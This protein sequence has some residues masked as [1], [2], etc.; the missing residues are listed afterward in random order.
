[1][2]PHLR[3]R[4]ISSC[5]VRLKPSLKPSPVYTMY[6]PM[7]PFTCHS[8]HTVKQGKQQLSEVTTN[9]LIAYNKLLNAG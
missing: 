7:Y 8:K 2:G 5:T 3:S 1:M 4:V 9:A 6:R